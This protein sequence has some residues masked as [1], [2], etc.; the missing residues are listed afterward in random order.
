MS[1]PTTPPAGGT[2]GA[3]GPLHYDASPSGGKGPNGNLAETW[4]RRAS[5]VSDERVRDASIGR[6]INCAAEKL[7][8]DYQIEI[9]IENGAASV[10][11]IDPDANRQPIG[12]DSDNRLAAEINEAIRAALAESK[13]DLPRGVE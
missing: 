5:L 11:L 3:S 1:E 12:V 4:N 2:C 9:E 10:T 6:A 13:K 7:P 8:D